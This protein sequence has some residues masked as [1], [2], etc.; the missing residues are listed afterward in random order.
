[1]TRIQP[2]C[3]FIA[4][5]LVLAGPWPLLAQG[6]PQGDKPGSG[7]EEPK[8][9]VEEEIVVQARYAPEDAT[10]ATKVPTPVQLIPASVSSLSST[11]LTEQ[12]ATTLDE[13]MRNVPGASTNRDAGSI[14]MFFL[15]GLDS[16]SDGLLLTDGAY[17][18]RTGINQTYNVDRVE[19][20]R[21][22]IGFLYGGNSTAGAVNLVR[23]RPLA[24]N[25]CRVGF[26]G[27]S[28][29]STYDT[30]DVNR[31][32]TGSQP[33][34]R[35]NAMWS[36]S[37][38]YRDR[39]DSDVYAVNPSLTW[40][41]GERTTINADLETQRTRGKID[42]G[43]PLL[44]GSLPDVPRTQAY[45]SPFDHYSQDTQ[46]V[47]VNLESRLGAN[48]TLRDKAYYTDQDWDNQG[49]L[50]FGVFPDPFGGFAVLRGFGILDQKVKVLGNQLDA[51]YSWRSGSID[52]ELVAG[53]EYQDIKVKAHL[54]VGLLPPIDL[55]HPVE[56]AQKPIPFLPGNATNLDL[57]NK[58]VAPY[59]LDTLHF[60][61]RWHVSVGGRMDFLDQKNAVLGLSQ[62]DSQLSPFLGVLFAPTSELSLYAN[63]GESFNPLSLAVASGTPKPEIGHGTEIGVK[64]QAFSGRLRTSVA[65]YTLEKK[66]IA[67]VDQTG[68]VAQLGDQK[69]KGIEVEINASPAPGLDLLVVYGYTDAELTR[70]A[71]LD[72]LTGI[73]FDRSGNVPAFVPK[74]T[75]STWLGKRFTNGFGIAGGVRYVSDR[76]INEANDFK[77]KSYVTLDASLAYR[78][79]HWQ[80]S[81]NLKNLTG[82]KYETRSVNNVAVIPAPG[83][84]ASAGIRLTR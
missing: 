19:V 64:S 28:Y 12:K 26:L 47:R 20:V 77:V 4:A 17:E 27:E 14:E 43:I 52:H 75:L 11:L 74:H 32:G 23:K 66:N 67:I 2:S 35:L 16:T 54:D 5:A 61:S 7:A 53:V 1:M 83:F 57:D 51:V 15:R 68:V 39:K 8:A 59:V 71:Q 65:V 58:T 50:L 33:S 62:S 81:I 70:F 82:E 49:T 24:E 29:A 46:R 63:H 38:G 41:A 9:A 79:P 6:P 42:G 30:V 78:R 10:T 37:D 45:E 56:T 18:P 3:L 13:A 40:R 76:F 48:L 72:P 55:F 69:S 60:S 36:S 73:V 84:N 31:G 80:A 25:F 21:G 44:A 22:P 34:L